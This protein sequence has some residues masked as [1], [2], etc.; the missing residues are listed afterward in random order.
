MSFEF[1]LWICWAWGISSQCWWKVPQFWPRTSHQ[2]SPFCSSEHDFLTFQLQHLQQQSAL[3]V[4]LPD[5][6]ISGKVFP[7]HGSPVRQREE[8]SSSTGCSVYC[9]YSTTHTPTAFTT[10][11][12]TCL[13]PGTDQQPQTQ[14]FGGRPVASL[15]ATQSLF[16]ETVWGWHVKHTALLLKGWLD[17]KQ[18]EL[19][20]EAK[21]DLQ[22]LV[23]K[24]TV[25]EY[26]VMEARA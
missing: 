6:R 12:T 18:W 14:P 4:L 10:F 22:R 23:G 19:F 20:H 13:A 11:P 1:K 3:P 25:T 8:S 17:P 26:F 7:L 16:L 15:K 21:T 9:N 2:K 5:L 24:Y